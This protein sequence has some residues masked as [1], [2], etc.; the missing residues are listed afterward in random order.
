MIIKVLPNKNIFY[1]FTI[2]N[3][4]GYDDDNGKPFHSIRTQV[5]KDLS[6]P[7]N[8]AKLE[9]LKNY[10]LTD[11]MFSW[12][13]ANIA[14]FSKEKLSGFSYAYNDIYPESLAIYNKYASYFQ[15]AVNLLKL[16]T[17]YETE[18]K[19]PYQ[20]L[21]DKLIKEIG[22][23]QIGDLL[24]EFWGISLTNWGIYYPNPL[25][26]CYRASGGLIHEVLTSISGPGY[27]DKKNDTVE[28]TGE[29]VV[30]SVLHEFSHPYVRAIKDSITELNSKPYQK[31]TKLLFE[32][33]KDQLKDRSNSPVENAYSNWESYFNEQVVR[34]AEMAFLTPKAFAYS[35]NDKKT[36]AYLE[37]KIRNVKNQGFIFID[38]VV[39]V[40]KKVLKNNGSIKEA[41]IKTI[42]YL[43][44]KYLS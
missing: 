10:W 30:H 34:A 27:Y 5:R 33:A 37:H 9:E 15:N 1:L 12:N 31:K 32:Y 22:K 19:I 39:K 8:V 41:W 17:Y 20:E 25:D 14:L 7:E 11:K 6:T 21:I 42:D 44:L 38:D 28:F 43:S 36:S 26:A 29:T 2:L 13:L 23:I 35:W 3:L 16:P 18:M 4:I 40:F 24:N